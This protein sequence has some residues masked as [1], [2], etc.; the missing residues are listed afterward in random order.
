VKRVSVHCVLS[1]EVG[2]LTT[3]LAAECRIRWSPENV[4]ERTR[5]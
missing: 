5:L 3:T 1:A 2:A 4:E